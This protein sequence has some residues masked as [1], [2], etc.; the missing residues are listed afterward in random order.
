MK[1][2][3]LASLPLDVVRRGQ[4]PPLVFLH[5]FG[6]S[7]FTFRAW[8]DDLARANE[9]HLI[10]LF[11]CGSA[12]LPANG[13]YGAVE[14]AEV[15]TRYLREAD[16]R[17]VTVIGHSLGGGVALLAAHRLHQLGEADRLVGLVNVAGPAYAQAIPRFIALAR[18]PLLG[19]LFLRAVGP[20]RIVRAV[21]RSILFDPNNV[22]DALVE[23]YA[24]PLRRP[25]TRHALIATARQI[26]PDHLDDL[27]SGFGDIRTPTLLLWGRHDHVVPLWVGERLAREMQRAQLVVLEQCGHVPPEERPHESLAALRKFL[28]ENRV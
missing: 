1:R 14:Q 2:P 25:A 26:V 22:T 18:L 20:D 9:L 15:V 28:L 12:P 17:G 27:V 23:G 6:A 21:L 3:T 16:L 19:M 8:A 13:C 11:G 4:G 7:R 10:D 24:D 5:G